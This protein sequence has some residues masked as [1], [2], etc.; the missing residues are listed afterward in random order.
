MVLIDSSARHN[1]VSPVLVKAVQAT[2]INIE[3]ICVTLGKKLKVLII[4]LANLSILFTSGA[5]QIV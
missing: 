4:K 5:A 3:P 1:F 2:T